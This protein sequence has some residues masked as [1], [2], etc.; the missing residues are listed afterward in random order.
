[1]K[2]FLKI[3]ITFLLLL[4]SILLA[5][6]NPIEK[7]LNAI[8]KEAIKAQLEF[9]ASDWTEGRETTTKGE[10]LAGDYIASM[11]K[12]YGVKPA[13]DMEAGGGGGRRM[14]FPMGGQRAQQAQK[15][16]F[17][18]INFVESEASDDQLFGI[19]IKEG[20]LRKKITFN[21]K[22]DYMLAS[23]GIGIEVEAPIVFVGYGIRDEEIGYDDFKGLDLKGKIVFRL[24]G[25]PGMRD[26]A[27]AAFKKL[28]LADRNSLMKYY[29]N[30][31]EVPQKLGAVAVI[32]YSPGLDVSQNAIT[33]YPFRYNLPYYEG[34][35]RLANGIH[36]VSL[37][38]DTLRSAMA[39]INVSPRVANEILK[40]SGINLEEF[41]KEAAKN[42]KPASKE[43]KDKSLFLKTTVKTK[44]VRG[45]NVV[46][47]IEGENPNEVIVVGGHYDHVGT[48]N[49]YIWN[50]ADDNASG[51][52]GVMTIAK[53]VMATGVKPKRTII[54]AAWTG[55]EKGLL[56]SE[57]F[58]SKY[59]PIKNI[60][61]NLNYDMIGRNDEKDTK[62]VKLGVDY[63]STYPVLKDV[64][65]RANKD[66]NLG[67]EITFDGAVRP[68]GGSDFASFA[69][70]D[71][72]VYGVMAAMHEDYHQPTDHVEKI[73]YD[74][75]TNIIKLGFLA[76]W[77]FAN[78]EK[79]PEFVK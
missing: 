55:E 52:V 77:E 79:K 24:T 73:N 35:K 33:N 20:N 68:S 19:N 60:I 67:L 42:F 62:G 59:K 46:G 18:N 4:S 6:T 36:R 57:Y 16:F 14:F 1:M 50:G 48:N 41:E 38:E 30:R 72:P 21:Y 75:M 37:P 15:S 2:N 10:F 26:T 47:V 61:L 27:S 58:V 76:V 29:R 13:G 32:D 40:G 56:G 43:L 17:Q 49:G 8:S 45:R 78:S 53:A 25:L 66:L 12:L 34:E 31:N 11:L 54:F 44:V 7:G 5:Q 74:K 69:E 39:S 3:K 23:G 70:K 28:K 9:L 64:M 51:T 71:I 65:E 63:T 22:S